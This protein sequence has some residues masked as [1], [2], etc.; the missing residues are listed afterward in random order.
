[1]KKPHLTPL[2]SVWN[3]ILTSISMQPQLLDIT[4]SAFI[5]NQANAF[6]SF[7]TDWFAIAT[8][9]AKEK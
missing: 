3:T 1:M 7:N 8:I 5:E 2:H 6:Y 9:Q 4:F